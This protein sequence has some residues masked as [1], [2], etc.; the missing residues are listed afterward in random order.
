MP[1]RADLRISQRRLSITTTAAAILAIVAALSLAQRIRAVQHRYDDVD[2]IFFYGWWTDYSTGGDPWMVQTTKTELRPGLERQRYCNHTP[3]FVEVFSP[4]AR[5][6]QK[7]AFWIWQAAQMICLVAAVLMLA[8]GNAPPLGTAPTIIVLSLLLLSR[9]FAG[10]LVM[11]EVTPMLLA[12]LS[13][14]WFCARRERPAAAGL[15]LALAA[16]VKLYPVTAGGYFLFGRRWRALGWAIGC[17]VVGVVLTNPAHWIELATLDTPVTYG[18]LSR[19]ELTVLPFV[20]KCVAH[21]A[22]TTTLAAPLFAVLAITALIDLALLAIAAAATIASRRRADLD[23]LLFGLW[24]ALALLMSPLAWIHETLLLLPLYLFGMLAAWDGFQPRD[25]V[26][27]IALIS[28][29]SILA[30]CI[31]TA[32]IKAVPHPGFPVLLAAYLG[33]ALIFRARMRSDLPD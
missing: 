31:V 3:F 19:A 4:L 32:L 11:A 16:L 22:G 17:F 8:R 33:A 7:T 30:V 24:V 20:R 2:F 9:Q 28:G 14:S 25:A 21:F 29:A 6:D 12:L 15:C 18:N 26:R 1:E 5:F 13:A 27:Q 10:T 23:G